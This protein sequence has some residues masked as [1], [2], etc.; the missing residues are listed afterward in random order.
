MVLDDRIR[1]AVRH[2]ARRRN[3]Q[4]A[5][6]RD[7]EVL[8]LGVRSRRVEIAAGAVGVERGHECTAR[9]H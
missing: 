9:L 2:P 3:G 7:G 4:R 1:N 6:Q 8:V 5:V